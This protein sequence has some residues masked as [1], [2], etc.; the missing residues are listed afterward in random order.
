MLVL[1]KL[2]LAA[3]EVV[4]MLMPSAEA[5][6]THNGLSCASVDIGTDFA[7]G[8]SSYWRGNYWVLEHRT[9]IIYWSDSLAEAKGW[10]KLCR[11]CVK[12]TTDAWAELHRNI[13]FGTHSRPNLGASQK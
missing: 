1:S 13:R 6:V 5:V 12:D 10:I 4:T 7:L 8:K 11:A 2:N 9:G 3:L